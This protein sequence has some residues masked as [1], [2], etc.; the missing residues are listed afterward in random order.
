MLIYSGIS[1][2]KDTLGPAIA[3]LNREVSSSQRY[4]EHTLK[5]LESCYLGQ[6]MCPL[7]R[8][9]CIMFLIQCSL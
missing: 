9:F 4:V 5:V 1:H 2:I 8:G 3:V 7:Y 6:E